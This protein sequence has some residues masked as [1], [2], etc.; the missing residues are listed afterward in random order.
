[1]PALIAV[2]VFFACVIIGTWGF[3]HAVSPKIDAVLD[4]IAS[5]YDRYLPRITIRNGRASIEQKQPY[6]VTSLKKKGTLVVIDTRPYKEKE[7]LNYLRSVRR[8][9]VLTRE[10]LVVKKPGQI[11]I[12]ALKDL[13]DLVFDSKNLHVMKDRYFPAAVKIGTVVVGFYFFAAKIL[14]IL[15]FA[16]IPYFGAWLSKNRVTYGGALKVATVA[17]V[18]PVAL[19][20]FVGSPVMGLSR[21]LWPYFGLYLVLLVAAALDL[22][23]GAGLDRTDIS[24][25]ITP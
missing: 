11:R 8:G 20:L 14:Q 21:Y 13:P 7:A 9:V 19:D 10:S 15:L 1:M 12:F 23:K 3:V 17:M 16:L 5:G 24:T 6:V 18:P 2:L 25:P 4:L 22:A